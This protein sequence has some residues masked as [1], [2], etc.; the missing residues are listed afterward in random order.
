MA[1]RPT[2]KD[3]ANAPNSLV[4]QPSDNFLRQGFTTSQPSVNF[5]TGL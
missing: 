3:Y 1:T 5:L 2:Q 4:T